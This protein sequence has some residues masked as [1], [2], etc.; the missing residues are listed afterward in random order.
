VD[1]EKDNR[2]VLMSI[3]RILDELRPR[4]DGKP[5]NELMESVADRP[6]HDRRY[7]TD[8]SKFK[9]TFSWKPK[10]SFEQGIERTVRW[11]LDNPN[12][13]EEVQRKGYSGERL[14]LGKL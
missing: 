7:A 13:C 8:A 12:W 3:C 6:G 2:N 14:G 1:A 10:V 9:K 5:H 4:S 11:Y